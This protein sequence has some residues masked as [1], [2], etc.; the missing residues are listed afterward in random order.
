LVDFSVKSSLP[1]EFSS[2][3]NTFTKYISVFGV[4]FFATATVEDEKLIHAAKVMAGY[5]DNNQDGIVDNQ[6]II[7]SMIQNKAAMVLAYDENEFETLY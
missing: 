4:H 3:S 2:F 7:L 6:S 5:L 1:S